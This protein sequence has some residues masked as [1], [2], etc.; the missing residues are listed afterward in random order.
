MP[1]I[2]KAYQPQPTDLLCSYHLEPANGKTLESVTEELCSKAAIDASIG[3]NREALAARAYAITGN[4]VKVAYPA[5]HFEPGNIPQ[6]LSVVAGRI[7]G[8]TNIANLRLLDIRFPEWWVKSFRGPAHGSDNLHKLLGEP[9][10]PLVSALI[11]PEVGMDLETYKKKAF[12]ALMGGCDMVRDSHQLTDLPNNRFEQR[13]KAVLALTR[14]AAQKSELPKLYFPNVTGPGDI[15]LKRTRFAMQAGCRGVVI[16]FATCGFSAL[17]ILRNE[18]PELIIYA[19]RT[20]HGAAARNKRH[21]ISMT[22]L[23]KLAR[24]AGADLI[25]IGSITGDMIETHAQVVQLHSNLLAEH[26]TTR[27]PERFDQNWFGL[28]KSL[29]VISGGLTSD[30]IRELRYT[31]GHQM[32][33]QF[34]RSMTG[35]DHITPEHIERFLFD[36]GPLVPLV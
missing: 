10:R 6:V 13:V 17:Q 2:D 1:Y 8:L 31:F 18:F 12:A 11:A 15:V 22:T 30:D 34:G 16:D 25:E 20:S 23:G 35:R 29:P 21:G 24:L 7:F 28:K 3:A 4:N 14:E 33:L 26:F 5:E 27:N 19:D 9:E 32:V 36:M